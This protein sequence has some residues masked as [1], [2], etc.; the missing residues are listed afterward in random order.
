MKIHLGEPIRTLD[1]KDAGVI[2]QVILD[3][4]SASI[5]SVVLRKGMIL[6]HDVQVTVDELREDD[7]GHHSLRIDSAHLDELPH[8]DASLYTTPPPDLILNEDYLPGSALWPIGLG[9][10]PIMVPPPTLGPDRAV[11]DELVARIYQ[12]DLTN[13]VVDAGSEILSRDDHKVGELERLTFSEKGGLLTSIVVRQG[14]LFHRETE[15]PSSMVDRV[16]DG[17]IYLNVDEAVVEALSRDESKSR[18]S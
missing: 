13:A 16:D 2:D 12:D 1:D 18:H 6:T 15:I 9:A 10:R 3:P 17:V 8:F 7:T 14:F 4:E 11:R 5:E